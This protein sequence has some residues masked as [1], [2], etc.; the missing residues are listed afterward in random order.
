MIK[1]DTDTLSDIGVVMNTH[2]THTH[3]SELVASIIEFTALVF[4]LAVLSHFP[5]IAD[6]RHATIVLG[7]IGFSARNVGRVAPLH[8]RTA[9]TSNDA[10]LAI[11]VRALR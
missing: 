5:H 8:R 2:L 4:F 3:R 1:P 6:I 11:L 10:G 7:L 9:G